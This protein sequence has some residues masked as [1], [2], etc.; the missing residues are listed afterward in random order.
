MRFD[1][2]PDLTLADARK[3]IRRA[4]AKAEDLSARGAFVVVNSG[5]VPISASRMDNAGAFGIPV[6][7]AKAF[8]AGIYFI[9]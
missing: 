5:G 9:Q 3:F 1:R 8:I 4:V 2:V 6:S 7:R